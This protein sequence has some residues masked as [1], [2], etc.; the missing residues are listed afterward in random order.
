[1]AET[2]TLKALREAVAGQL[3]LLIDTSID[4]DTDPVFTI[5]AL[6]DK[7]PDAERMRDS[8]LY[9][10]G[11]WR[12]IISF[13]YPTNDNVTVTRLS[14]I[15]TGA[16]QVYFML[17]PDELNAAINEGLKEL[18]FE[19]VDSITLVA[20]TYVYTLP[21]WIQTKGQLIALKWRDTSLLTTAPH[22]DHVGGYTPQEDGNVVSVVIHDELRSVT[23]YDL[24]VIGRRNYS[25]LANDAAT[26]TC[27]YPLI[28]AVAMVK[29]LHKIFN[30][31]GKGIASLYG[32]KM[33]VS[34]GEMAKAKMDWLPKLKAREYIEEERWQGPDQSPYFNSPTW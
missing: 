13:G 3:G 25:A 27:P 18:Y 20:N 22:E 1:M 31:Y 2:T 11:V 16:A 32:P 15:T 33:Q 7:T 17:D 23:T 21:A 5:A 30:K 6:S 10:S 4:T 14:A 26:T 19:D 8:F 34:E 28:F 9:Q 12:R 29:V 24:R